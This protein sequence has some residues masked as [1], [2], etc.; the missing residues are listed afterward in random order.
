[1]ALLTRVVGALTCNAV[2]FT[3]QGRVSL[4]AFAA[5]DGVRITVRDTGIGIP[6]EQQ[7]GLF[8][9]FTQVDGAS[10]RRFGGAGLGLA[11]CRE[12]TGL[13]GGA[14]SVES[15]PGE[16]SCFIVDLPLARAAARRAA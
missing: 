9:K 8:R 6:V 14:V 1:V 4:K 12:L 10:T 5:G 15:A 13:M 11:I 2:K 7:G 3:P 16:G